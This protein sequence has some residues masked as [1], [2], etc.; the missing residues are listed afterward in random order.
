MRICAV[1][2]RAIGDREGR[3]NVF[4]VRHVTLADGSDGWAPI[5]IRCIGAP[6]PPSA[7]EKALPWPPGRPLE[8]ADHGT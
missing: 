5:H 7:A 4:V 3:E 8:V 6:W 2:G 1:C